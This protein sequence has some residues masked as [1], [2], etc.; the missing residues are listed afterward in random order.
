M[1]NIS[2]FS[3][4]YYVRRLDEND[5]L[6]ILSLELSNPLYYEYCKPTPT[7]E[8]II[9]DIHIYPNKSSI[10]NKYYVGYF[11]N[12]ELICILDLIVSYPLDN[13][14]FI[15]F[16]MVDKKYSNKGIGS[17]IISDLLNYLKNYYS[18]IRLGYVIG[19]KQSESFWKKNGFIDFIKTNS[20]TVNEEIMLMR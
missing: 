10:D 3:K 20:N 17:K 18:E 4:E 9:K 8:S 13:I 19:N 11:N 7:K 2:D 14:S 15:G 12:E 6:R 16:F 5:T 1:L